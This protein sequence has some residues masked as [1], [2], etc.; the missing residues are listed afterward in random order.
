MPEKWQA[1]A[2]G[3]CFC[4][5]LLVSVILIA[6]SFST[7]EPNEVG[8][9]YNNNRKTVDSEKLWTGGRHFLGLGHGFVKYPTFVQESDLV[10]DGRSRDGMKVNLQCSFQWQIVA[11]IKSVFLL[12]T[13]FNQ[14]YPTAFEK[15]AKD[16]IRNVAAR[17]SA[18]Q[19]FF[20]RT[21]ITVAME[22]ELG[23]ALTPL[24]ATISG[25]Q[26][27]NYAL[28]TT[29]QTAIQATEETRQRIQRVK[30]E[31]TK[32]AIQAQQK[33]E[34]ASQD[35]RILVVKA[36]AAAEAFLREKA[37]ERDAINATLSAE[38]D[39]YKR[40]KDSLNL[41]GKG[42]L[43]MI[44]LTAIQSTNARQMLNVPIPDNLYSANTAAP[45][46]D[47]PAMDIM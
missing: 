35:A 37:A 2:G 43:T 33:K 17:F 42:L 6:V 30:A 15:I 23:T 4:V 8:L 9:D 29:F 1:I 36:Q 5:L 38:R 34:T 7:L 20:N 26:L 11:D 32:A 10:L 44:W 45:T 12:Y 28:P 16:K 22:N 31:Q 47:S 40:L 18:F 24:G 41:D 25:F 14:E 27:L 3:S 13:A 39:T 19:F 21:D 46:E